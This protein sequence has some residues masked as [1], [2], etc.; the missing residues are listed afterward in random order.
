MY[1]RGI[2]VESFYIFKDIDAYKIDIV[3]VSDDE[4]LG[5]EYNYYAVA[6]KD[7]VSMR[8]GANTAEEAEI[9]ADEAVNMVDR[10][11]SVQ[12]H[13]GNFDKVYDQFNG[14]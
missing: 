14:K 8:Q 4:D 12:K 7:G 13:S 3:S 6:T 10:Q 5:H 9:L 1:E 2:I 11:I